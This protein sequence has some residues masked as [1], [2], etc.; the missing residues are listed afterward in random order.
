MT[1]GLCSPGNET[2]LSIAYFGKFIMCSLD[3]YCC[4]HSMQTL[5]T[6]K[7]ESIRWHV[8]IKGNNTILE[9]RNEDEFRHRSDKG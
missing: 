6:Q 9:N 5:V 1:G 3:F 2:F 4:H 7:N 8:L